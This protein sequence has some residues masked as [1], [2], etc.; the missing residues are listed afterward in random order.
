[1]FL[2]SKE[3]TSTSLTVGGFVQDS[4]SILD[5]VTVNAGVRYDAQTIWGLDGKMGLHLPHQWSPRI[6]VIYDF[7]QQ[8]RS[9]LFANYARFY[10]NIPLD[11]ADLSFPQQQ[12]LSATYNAQ[13]NPSDMAD[14]ASG[15]DCTLDANRQTRGSADS[16]NQKW[17]SEGGDRVPVDPNIR[18]QSSDEFVVGGEYEVLLGRVGLT[19][20]KRYLNDVIEDMSRD[21]GTTF[22]LGNPGKGYS[23]D[24]PVARRDYD[25]VNVYYT[26]AFSNQWL[27]Q[28]SY[29]WSSLRGNYSGLFRA[30][31][32]QLSPNLTRDFDLL[33]LT[34]NRDGP[35]P[36]DRTHAFKAFGARE[37]QLGKDMSLNLG[38]GYRARSGSP[39]NYLGYHPRR[40]GSETFI[41]PRG[42]AGRLPWVHN[43]DGHLGLNRRLSGNYTLSLTL[44]VFNVFN[45][46]Q[47]TDVDQTFTFAQVH[48]HRAGWQARGRG[49]LQRGGRPGRD[50]RVYL[51]S[52][53]LE[54]PIT[55]SESDLN[56]NFKKPIA[57]QAP[58]SIRFG[59]KLSF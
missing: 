1:M 4:W 7:T 27:A 28:V 48:A 2:A 20:T 11:M 25:A 52:S 53:S 55:I 3:G 22:F 14:L 17:A 40:S 54:S 46:Q 10:E 42:S 38:G 8:G 13:C 44:D 31:T 56:P 50:C 33:S 23:T 35:L 45:F 43:V 51:A 6:G 47:V 26:K 18:A 49:E 9:K 32:G 57:Y 16:P 29:T 58:R 59:V 24:F 34:V 37:F 41:L 19:Y 39:L 15:G 5:K 30:D 36:G 12:L 21:D